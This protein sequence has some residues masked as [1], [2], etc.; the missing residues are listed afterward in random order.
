MKKGQFTF[1]GTSRTVQQIGY[2]ATQLAARGYSDHPR[3]HDA[4]L[5]VLREAMRL[6]WTISAAGA[7][8]ILRS[9]A[10]PMATSSTVFPL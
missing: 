9:S 8:G 4:A 1:P 10:M 2:G 7:N 5:A 3:I 6:A